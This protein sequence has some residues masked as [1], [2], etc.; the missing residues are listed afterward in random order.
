MITTVFAG[1]GS[2]F[3]SFGTLPWYGSRRP[4]L[5]VVGSRCSVAV[6]PPIRCHVVVV[7]LFFPAPVVVVVFLNSAYWLG[8][9]FCADAWTRESRSYRLVVATG[10]PVADTDGGTS[11]GS[12]S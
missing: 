5:P 2:T 12:R 8:V 3:P 11:A 4:G 10:A 9:P 6:G 7:F 1:T